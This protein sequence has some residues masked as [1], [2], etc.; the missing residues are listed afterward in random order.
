MLT[1]S[2]TE[3]LNNQVNLEFYS[4][5][6]YL[7]MSAWSA[8]EGLEGCATFF[9]AHAAEEMGHMQ[10]LFDY[11][12][13]T[14][15]MPKLGA[16]EQPTAEFGSIRDVFEQTLNHEKY[17]TKQIN[18]LVETAFENKDFSTFQF[19]QWYVGEQHEEEALFQSIIDKIDL[20]GDERKGLFFL[21]REIATMA[22]AAA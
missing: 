16:I 3:K 10:K 1:Q 7:Q 21:D 15:G 6:L 14:G 8:H 12:L 19:L 22:N 20:I 13:M 11:I 18:G 17:I 4:S 5:N 9:K 2:M